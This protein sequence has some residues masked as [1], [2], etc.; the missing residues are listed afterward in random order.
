VLQNT[1]G[2]SFAFARCS[3]VIKVSQLSP[4]HSEIRIR[5]EEISTSEEYLTADDVKEFVSLEM[6]SSYHP[7]YFI[8][9]EII[10]LVIY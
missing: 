8:S 2:N 4:T 10:D 1:I 9:G 7:T 3:C 6:A 5:A